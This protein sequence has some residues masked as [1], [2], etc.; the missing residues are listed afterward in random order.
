VRPGTTDGA[1]G[2]GRGAE[3][4]QRKL[5]WG[6]SGTGEDAA[7]AGVRGDG[8]GSAGPAEGELGAGPGGEVRGSASAAG[9]VDGGSTGGGRRGSRATLIGGWEER[10]TSVN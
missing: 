8:W 1:A 2:C 4:E 3:G 9:G 5:G 7:L 6:R 10:L